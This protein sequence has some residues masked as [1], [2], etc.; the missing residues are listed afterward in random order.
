MQQ[1]LL[2]EIGRLEIGRLRS[3]FRR[4][5]TEP[6]L[7]SGTCTPVG[8]NRP[9]ARSMRRTTMFSVSWFDENTYWPVGSI[10]K[11]R[12]VRP[13]DAACSTTDSSPARSMA[14]TAMLPCPRFETYRNLP[15]ESMRIS[16]VVLLPG[17]AGGQRRSAP[18]SPSGARRRPRTRSPENRSREPDREICRS[19]AAAAVAGPSRRAAR[20]MADRAVPSS[21]SR[22]RVDSCR[23]GRGR[24]RR[25]TQ[26][27]CRSKTRRRARAGQAA[28]TAA[29]AALRADRCRRR[30]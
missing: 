3:Y 22:H 2:K 4:N 21:A 17:V 29:A 6:G 26:N 13:P 16:A 9:V 14:Y 25:R 28:S 11:L 8:V 27:G 20:H 18:E 30:R 23:H 5:A 24:C 12:G 7:A 19:G 15:A 10:E 1:I